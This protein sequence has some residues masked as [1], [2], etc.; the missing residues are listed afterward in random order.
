MSG[1]Q[2]LLSTLTWMNSN[3]YTCNV[4]CFLWATKQVVFK[5]KTQELQETVWLSQ[6]LIW[7]MWLVEYVL[8]KLQ[9]CSMKGIFLSCEST[10]YWLWGWPAKKTRIKQKKW[11]SQ[12]KFISVCHICPQ[13]IYEQCIIRQMSEKINK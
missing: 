2:C 4:R 3:V 8:F 9:V 5:C 7:C 12:R 6:Q 13:M 11:S 10:L 1:V